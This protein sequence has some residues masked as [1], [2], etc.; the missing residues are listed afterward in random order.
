[1]THITFTFTYGTCSFAHITFGI[2]FYHTNICFYYL[3]QYYLYPYQ[4]C[5]DPEYLYF[6]YITL[7]LTGSLPLPLLLPLIFPLHLPICFHLLLL[8]WHILCW[9]MLF[10]QKKHNPITCLA[11]WIT[12]LILMF[13]PTPHGV[14]INIT[15]PSTMII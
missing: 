10:R 3:Y 5:I 6:A 2:T 7:N 4:L 1:M 14:H 9:P 8:P 15:E 13:P 12:N 11:K